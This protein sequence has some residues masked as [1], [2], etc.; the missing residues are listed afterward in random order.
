[1]MILTP[2]QRRAKAMILTPQKRRA[3]THNDFNSRTEAGGSHNDSNS[4][5]EVGGSAR[6][7]GVTGYGDLWIPHMHVIASPL[8]TGQK[9]S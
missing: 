8:L 6:A 9:T 5:A 3:G 2:P 7:G 4:P 1:M